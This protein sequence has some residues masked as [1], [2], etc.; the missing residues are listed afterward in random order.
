[1]GLSTQFRADQQACQSTGMLNRQISKRFVFIGL[2]N[3]LTNCTT[4]QSSPIVWTGH[5]VTLSNIKER[6]IY[7]TIQL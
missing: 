2:R 6:V 3:L 5:N 1:M 4:H 7:K